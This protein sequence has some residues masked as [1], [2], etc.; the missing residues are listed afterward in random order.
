MRM[1]D[2]ALRYADRGW[3]VFPLHWVS[4]RRCSCGTACGK[5]AGKHPMTPDGFYSATVDPGR[6]TEWWTRYPDANIGIRTGQVSNLWVVDQDAKVMIDRGD[7]LVIPEGENSIRTA[8]HQLGQVLT[9]TLTVKTGSGGL[10]F[11]YDYPQDGEKHGSRGGIIPS[12][13]IRGDEGYVVAP[14]SVHLNGHEYQWV[15]ESEP[16]SPAPQWFVDFRKLEQGEPFIPQ[17]KVAEGGRNNYLTS[18]AGSLRAHGYDGDTLRNMVIGHNRMVCVPPL[19]DAEALKVAESVMRYPAGAPVLTLI[20]DLDEHGNPVPP[21]TFVQDP[22]SVAISLDDFLDNP[23]APKIPVIWEGILD[24]ADGFIIGGQSGVGKSWIAMDMALSIATGTP[25]LDAFATTPGKV[26]YIDEEGS[27]SGAYKRLMALMK[28]RGITGQRGIPLH[29]VIRKSLKFDSPEGLA[30]ISR[31]IYDTQ[32]TVVICD[33]LVRMHTGEENSA[34]DMARFF[35]LSSQLR[36]AYGVAIGFIHHTRKPSKEDA[37]DLADMM[38]GSGDIRGWPDSIL[39]AKKLE[40]VGMELHHAK[41]REH[42]QHKP[43]EVRMDIREDD[44]YARLE[45]TG[46]V[47]KKT[48]TVGETRAAIVERINVIQGQAP[49]TPEI[50]AGQMGMSLGTIHEHLRVLVAEGKISENPGPGRGTYSVINYR[51]RSL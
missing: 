21:K 14:P 8:E 45:V 1:M 26:V 42:P 49:V 5:N 25:W 44:A 47:Q 7:G 12:V 17:A 15:D 46:G 38:R 32:P 39:I 3:H 51:Q 27:R 22:H 19:D 34:R 23:P 40:G 28:G 4:N 50:I 30:T 10:H 13:D 43:V 48:L 29:M 2:A 24:E 37:G 11:Y 18:Y 36:E 35:D 31:I 33:T 20:N 6:I 16:I 41:S 9:E